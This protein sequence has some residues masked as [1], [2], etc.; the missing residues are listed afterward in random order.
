MI[1]SFGD[2]KHGDNGSGARP[3]NLPIG[4]VKEKAQVFELAT[5]DAITNKRV[6]QS[7]KSPAESCD[8]SV[9]EIEGKQQTSLSDQLQCR[10]NQVESSEAVETESA[11]ASVSREEP[12][13]NVESEEKVHSH[14]TIASP[15]S[16]TLSAAV[17]SAREN[18]H[19]EFKFI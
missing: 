13:A 10:S 18:A 15:S 19:N 16:T 3:L 12:A 14:G 11:R 1:C 9:V 5:N 2:K 7:S 8:D 4:S 17:S 6:K